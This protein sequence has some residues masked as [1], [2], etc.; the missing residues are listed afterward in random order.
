MS[1]S[2]LPGG[3][4]IVTLPA[5]SDWSERGVYAASSFESLM[6]TPFTRAIRTLKRPEGRAP[7]AV[8]RLR[9]P[10]G[11]PPSTAGSNRQI[12]SLDCWLAD[13]GPNTRMAER[14][15]TLRYRQRA[16]S[17]YFMKRKLSVLSQQY[18]AALK[19]H[20][21]RGRR[22][23]LQPA[24][25][26]GRRAVALR[27]ET[28][29]LARIHERAL[30]ALEFSNSENGLSQRAESFFNEAI[31][32]IVETHRAA[33]QSKIDLNRLNGALNRRTLELAATNRQLQRGIVQ[34]KGVEAALKKSGLHYSKLLRD[35]LQLQEGLRQLTHQVLVAQED[36]RRKISR[37][38][39]D[40]IAQTLLGI[41]VRLLSLKQEARGNT[42]GLKNEI[43]STQRLV[44]KSARSVRR[45]A[46]EFRNA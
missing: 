16:N 43:A 29:E 27:L 46:R 44:A 4:H 1:G 11:H 24:L 28:L 40:E 37:E 26:L 35:S 31:T 19:K 20:L 12:F 21:K 5:I 42:R 39:Q 34:R 3:A 38:L 41:N 22:A 13:E 45:V 18:A 7:E 9:P 14:Q 36:E 30:A 25:K 8:S 10:G 15:T 32:P 23:N 33:R 2:R 6:A 17:A